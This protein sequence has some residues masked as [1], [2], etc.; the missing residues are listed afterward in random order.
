V[1]QEQQVRA[2]VKANRMMSELGGDASGER[3]KSGEEID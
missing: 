3:C 1:Q 2:G